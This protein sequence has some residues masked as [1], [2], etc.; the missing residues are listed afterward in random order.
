MAPPVR[1]ATDLART[2][3]SDGLRRWGGSDRSSAAQSVIVL[4]ILMVAGVIW[5]FYFLF[6]AFFLKVNDAEPAD[7]A[8][9]SSGSHQVLVYRVVLSVVLAAMI[10]AWYRLLVRPTLPGAIPPGTIAAGM[11]LILLVLL[12]IE[13]PYRILHRN[14][15]PQGTYNGMQCFEVGSRNN[16]S[17]CCFIVRTKRRR[18]MLPVPA[19]DPG[20]KMEG[21]GDVFAPR[22]AAA[23]GK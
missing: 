19:S 12:M 10:A 1:R 2:S 11:A 20:L 14:T 9:L 4:Q 15:L 22:A 5:V 18:E 17:S 8:R 23:A 3:V 13:V 21:T 7:L 6:Q 16:R